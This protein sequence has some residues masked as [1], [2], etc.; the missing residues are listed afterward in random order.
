MPVNS[1]LRILR[2]GDFMLQANLDYVVRP[3]LK[4]RKGEEGRERREKKLKESVHRSK[5]SGLWVQMHSVARPSFQS[6]TQSI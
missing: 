1:A 3:C 4:G 2:Q 6:V 5:K